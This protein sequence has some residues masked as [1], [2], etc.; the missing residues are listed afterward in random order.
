MKILYAIQGTGNGHISR[1]RDI[2]PVLQKDNEVDILVSGSQADVQLPF[3]VKYQYQGLGFVFGKKGGIDIFETYKKSNLKVFLSEISCLPVQAYDLVINDFEPVSAWACWQQNKK[4][5]SLSHQAAVLNKQVPQPKRTDRV[6]KVIIKKYAPSTAQY[7]FHFKAY[8]TNIFTPVIREQV[9]DQ[10]VEE[11]GHYTVYLPAYED[12]RIVKVLKEFPSVQWQVFSKHNK[13]AF[14]EKKITV[15]PIN[16][17]AFIESMASSE[18]VLCGAGFETPAEALFMNKKL[19]V[20]PMKGQYEQQCN[21]AALT[22]MGVP[23]I[24]SLK[25][26]HAEKIK[27]W[28]ETGK[29]I[30]VDYPDNTEWIINKI[31]AEHGIETANEMLQP[32][33]KIYKAKK[34][35][36]LI[37]KKMAAIYNMRY[38]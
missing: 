36:Q 21:A 28:I 31:L 9:R 24:K 19:M 15:Q 2:I 11:K 12:S 10:V 13:K 7:G 8:D 23:V 6:G 5:I 29:S 1:A 32:G 3:E 33:K 25:L 34:L 18:G 17:E 35:R 27:K 38:T 4:C 26:K 14:K 16:N 37:L 20:I 30:S 22:D